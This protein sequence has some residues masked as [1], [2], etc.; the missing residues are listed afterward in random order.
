MYEIVVGEHSDFRIPFLAFRGTPTGI[1]VLK[2]CFWRTPF[3]HLSGNSH[4]ICSIRAQR[5]GRWRPA[6]RSTTSLGM[7]AAA[8]AGRDIGQRSA[9]AGLTTGEMKRDGQTAEIQSSSETRDFRLARAYARVFLNLR[10][11]AAAVIN[12]RSAPHSTQIILPAASRVR[13]A[14]RARPHQPITSRRCI[15]AFIRSSVGGRPW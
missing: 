6:E 11:G 9:V 5:M 15:C 12:L 14:R 3:H 2:F 10:L 7:G 1:D 8:L 4:V 13:D